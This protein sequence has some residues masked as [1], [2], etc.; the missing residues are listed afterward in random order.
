MR[1]F[2]QC[3]NIR[4]MKKYI[5]FFYIY[6]EIYVNLFFIKFK[7]VKFYNLSCFT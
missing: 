4:H 6:K 2:Q 5:S 7:N 1:N 3:V